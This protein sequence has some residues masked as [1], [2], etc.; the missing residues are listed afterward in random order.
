[1]Q[2]KNLQVVERVSTFWSFIEGLLE[3]LR[4]CENLYSSH[5]L[6]GLCTKCAKS[7][8]KKGISVLFYWYKCDPRAQINF[9][10][11]ISKIEIIQWYGDNKWTVGNYCYSNQS[12]VTLKTIIISQ[13]NIKCPTPFQIKAGDLE[14]SFICMSVFLVWCKWI[15]IQ[16]KK[17]L[18]VL[19]PPPP[20]PHSSVKFVDESCSIIK[21]GRRSFSI[22]LPPP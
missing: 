10:A 8:P 17:I 1:M 14:L 22:G 21:G 19:S 12:Y 7:S 5:P 11:H 18:H 16:L 6:D 9:I 13:E 2:S 4:C 15:F 20:S 3:D